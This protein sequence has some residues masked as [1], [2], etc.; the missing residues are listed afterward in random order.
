VKVYICADIEGVTGI[1]HW[2]ESRKKNNDYNY[3]AEQMTKEVIKACEGAIQA[4][5]TEVLVKDSH[6]TGRNI[7]PEKLPSEVKLIRGWSGHPFSMMQELDESFDAVL[8]IGQHSAA[9]AVG[10]PM[11]HTM[12]GCVELRL[13]GKIAS[14]FVINSYTAAFCNVPVV[15]LSGDHHLCTEAK[16]MIPNLA[17]VETNLGFGNSV[18]ANNSNQVLNSI[19]ELCKLACAEILKESTLKIPE[20]FLLEIE[21]KTHPDAYKASF[22]PGAELISPRVIQYSNESYFEILRAINFL[23]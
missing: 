19:K 1:A 11:A 6:G 8:M 3:F 7:N 15:F 21:Y 4:G 18:I 23:L 5:A 9:G 12:G 22:Y 13:N 16:Q 20:S 17:V 2:D 10:N 14:E